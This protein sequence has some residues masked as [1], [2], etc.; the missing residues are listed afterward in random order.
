LPTC[1]NHVIKIELSFNE[2]LL[3]GGRFDDWIIVGTNNRPECRL[4]GNG[5]LQYV[6]EIAVF[7][8]PCGTQMPSPGV[9]QNRIRI[10]QNPAV[11]LRGDENLIVKC[12]YGLPEVNQLLIPTVN[13]SFS[14]V[15]LHALHINL[16]YFSDVQTNSLANDVLTMSRES[17]SETNDVQDGSG[18]LAWAALLSIMG[19]IFIVILVL[20]LLFV[21][22]RWRRDTKQA[23]CD[24]T[25]IGRLLIAFVRRSDDISKYG[26]TTQSWWA[27]SK[28]ALQNNALISQEFVIQGH[29]GLSET[30]S[31]ASPSVSV[32]SSVPSDEST[33][34]HS[35]K[36]TEHSSGRS[37]S[38][39]ELQP[40]SYSEWRNRI[41]HTKNM[42]LDRC[43]SLRASDID[44]YGG[45][46]SEVRS[47]T[48]IYR[49]AE[50][51][52]AEGDTLSQ[53]TLE[54]G[55]CNTENVITSGRLAKCV[56]KIR[57]FGPRKLTE[58]EL[59]RWRQLVAKDGDLQKAISEARDLTQLQQLHSLPRYHALFTAEKWSNIMK[60]VADV[61]FCANAEAARRFTKRSDFQKRNQVCILC[62][63]YFHLILNDSPTKSVFCV[64]S[65]A[66]K[67]GF[68]AIAQDEIS[69]AFDVA[70]PFYTTILEWPGRLPFPDGPRH[71]SR[72]HILG[73]LL[74][75]SF[76]YG[77]LLPI[78][79]ALI[80]SSFVYISIAVLISFFV[81]FTKQQKLLIS[82][83][84]CRLF[85]AGIGL[86]AKYHNRQFR[87][88]QPGK[89]C[90]AV[91]NHLSPN[92]IQIINADVEPSA[93]FGFTVTGQKH[94]GII[95]A[96]EF[97]AERVAPALW[98][99]R[100]NADERKK[101]TDDVIKEGLRGGPVLLFPEGYCTNNTRVLQFRRALF[102]DGITI[103]PIAIKQNARF[104]DSFWSDDQFWRYLLRILT[105]WAVVYDVFYLEPQ[106]RLKNES[107]QEFAARVQKLIA[108][109][110]SAQPIDYDGRLWYKTDEQIRMK[111]V[112]M[113][114]LSKRLKETIA[115]E[116]VNESIIESCDLVDHQKGFEDALPSL[117]TSLKNIPVFSITL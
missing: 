85:C 54:G 79:F 103:Y 65:D 18:T 63:H 59:G 110:A 78:R 62:S 73:Y 40:H 6:I 15:T 117:S 75:V 60:C 71:I 68:E 88:K 113:K 58:Q 27:G 97:L 38:T 106:R 50:M 74:A 31:Q 96:I 56:E 77:V 36:C 12:M 100:S 55:I 109:A 51:A 43:A 1:G 7:N 67:A 86:V 52:T 115:S 108:K 11:I 98:L 24:R 64:C 84:Y 112:Q 116:L 5:E 90:I 29:E 80:L 22:I 10:A 114:N 47:I 87:P 30:T 2:E 53:S 107:A 28:E 91:S 19:T 16:Q 3:A 20:M 4:K 49:S 42:D 83:T 37:T 21:C 8:D 101:F 9:F 33:N 111:H 32:T 72:W 17:A 48:E 41:I 23:I 82:V 57:G 76:R 69:V 105:S 61:R 44:T 39:A 35:A 70:P 93:N 26:A 104:G 66:I 94:S 81:S 14:A 25:N 95:W 45:Q 92:D 89:S 13:P 102:E 99:D 46:L 34:G